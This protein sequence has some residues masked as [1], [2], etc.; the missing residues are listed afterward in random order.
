MIILT[1]AFYLPNLENFVAFLGGK[2]LHI[3]FSYIFSPIKISL[4][5]LTM[6]KVQFPLA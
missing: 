1:N 4:L 5:P 2:N 6:A 3:I